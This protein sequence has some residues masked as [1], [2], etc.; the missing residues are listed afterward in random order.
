MVDVAA[1]DSY[2]QKLDKD[3]TGTRRSAIPVGNPPINKP[4]RYSLRC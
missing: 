4:A 1:R 2:I 3:K